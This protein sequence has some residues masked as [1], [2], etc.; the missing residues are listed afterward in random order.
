MNGP[1]RGIFYFTVVM[2][3]FMHYGCAVQNS[4]PQGRINESNYEQI[5][6]LTLAIIRLPEEAALAGYFTAHENPETYCNAGMKMISPLGSGR[7][8]VF[9]EACNFEN[10]SWN[11]G[12]EQPG[13]ESELP[14]QILFGLDDRDFGFFQTDSTF[15]APFAEQVGFSF[16]GDLT[17][18]HADQAEVFT[19]SILDIHFK[20]EFL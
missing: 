2:L 1:S 17:V 6:A 20:N 5:A 16:R 18:D 12:L 8:Q 15:F 14:Y 9:Y 13:D 4:A 19:G 10:I 11:G 3:I 7:V